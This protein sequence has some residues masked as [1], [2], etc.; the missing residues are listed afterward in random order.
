[1]ERRPQ[2]SPIW[3]PYA[4]AAQALGERLTR[5]VLGPGRSSSRLDDLTRRLHKELDRMMQQAFESLPGEGQLACAPGCDH[6]CRTLRVTVSPIE[7][8]IIVRRLR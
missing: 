1:M 5:A 6:C 8:F 7:V 2:P 4:Q 3:K